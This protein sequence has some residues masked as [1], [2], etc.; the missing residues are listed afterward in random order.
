MPARAPESLRVLSTVNC[1]GESGWRGGVSM[2]Q[3]RGLSSGRPL[4]RVWFVGMM[5][6]VEEFAVGVESGGCFL[7]DGGGDGEGV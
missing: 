1:I 2:G 5:C 7:G 4:T 3:G 6:L